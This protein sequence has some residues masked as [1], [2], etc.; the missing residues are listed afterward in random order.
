MKLQVNCYAGCRSRGREG[1]YKKR[2]MVVTGDGNGIEFEIGGDRQLESKW[3]G[4][5][6]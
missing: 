3:K 1:W 5:N 4:V 6:P 2:G